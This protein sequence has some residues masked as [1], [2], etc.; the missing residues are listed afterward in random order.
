MGNNTSS[1][2][3]VFACEVDDLED[4]D[5]MSV[6]ADGEPVAVYRIG[7]DFYATSDTCTHEQW[8]LGEEGDLDGFEITCTL[9]NARFDV[10][11][12]KAL[13]FPATVDLVRY[14]T[15]VEGGKVYVAAVERAA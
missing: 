6:R 5:S 11:S 7:D 4:G 9:H 1:T 15:I 12:G 14:S 10:R 13:C 2:E 3:R 8:S